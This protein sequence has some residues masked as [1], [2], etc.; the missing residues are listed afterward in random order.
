VKDIKLLVTGGNGLVGH[1]MKKLHPDAIYVSSNDFDL[2][3]ED[4]VKKMFE[5]HKPDQVIHLAA[6]VGGIIKN[7]NFPA[8][9]LYQNVMMNTLVV[10]YAYK[11]KVKKF[12]GVLSNCSYPDVA[13]SY[14]V[15][16]EYFYD[17]A[18]QKTN[19]AYAYSK[20]VLGVQIES[21]KKQYG[22]NFYS[23]IPCNLYGPYDNFD[24]ENSHFVPALIRK[25]HEAKISGK[26][27]IELMGTGK[28]LRQYLFSEDLAKILIILMKKYEWKG[29]VNIA[30]KSE[31]P[32]INEIA[33]IALEAMNIQD[34]DIIF[35]K[36]SPDG[37][38][39]KD[40]SI[41]KL[42]GIIGDFEFTPLKEGIKKTYE[43]YLEFTNNPKGEKL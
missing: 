39:R 35:D 23:A 29:A 41:E 27:T 12:I 24:K 2:T 32:S 26:K 6:K 1:A 19:F 38:Y 15:K 17:G 37:Q 43:W 33:R 4:Q 42:L 3:K 8:D 11:Y 21:Y 13:K 28:P 14:P 10:H 36:K 30:P 9:L 7:I 18:P 40:I 34:I 20:R 5:Q 31:N 22:C 16:E 25:I